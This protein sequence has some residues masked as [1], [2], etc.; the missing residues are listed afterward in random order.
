M[1][2]GSDR[3]ADR[4]PQGAAHGG[5][6]R[7]LFIYVCDLPTMLGFYRDTLGFTERYVSE[8]E[9]A[10]LSLGESGGTDLALYTGR[11]ER[12]DLPSRPHWFPVLN[13]PDLEASVAFLADAGV[14]VGS[15]E[16]VPYG[17]AVFL[18][19]PEGNVIELHQPDG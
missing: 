14:E 13:V 1:N 15:I 3:S 2:T 7:Y 16:S 5:S 19:D 11:E 10:F 8:G 4:I 18:T 17:R 9:F 12:S 6:L